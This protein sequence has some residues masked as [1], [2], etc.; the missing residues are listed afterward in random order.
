MIVELQN[1]NKQKD[2]ELKKIREIDQRLAL[3]P[4]K[5][6]GEGL[7]SYEIPS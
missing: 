4:K 6:R 7:T 5:S 1:A 3:D 2:E